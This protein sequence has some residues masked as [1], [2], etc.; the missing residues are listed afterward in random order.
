MTVEMLT[1]AKLAKLGSMGDKKTLFE[2][3]YAFQFGFTHENSVSRCV[4]G[5]NSV[6]FRLAHVHRQ[7]PLRALLS[8]ANE[9]RTQPMNDG[10]NLWYGSNYRLSN[11]RLAESCSLDI[12]V[13]FRQGHEVVFDRKQQDFYPKFSLP[14][15]HPGH[16]TTVCP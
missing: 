15:G 7:F 16:A 11:I 13:N 3:F 4:T 10:S 5:F 6:F 12:G 2:R 14:P 9:Q 1:R 8:T